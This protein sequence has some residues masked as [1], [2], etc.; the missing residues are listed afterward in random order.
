LPNGFQA[1]CVGETTAEYELLPDGQI[2][3]VNTCRKADGSLMRAEGRARLAER[4]GPAS[5]LKFRFAPS[6][7]SFLP[8]VWGDY[9]VLD[10][11]EDYHAA[12]VGEPGRQYLWILSRSPRLDDP[13]LRRMLATASAQG[14]DVDRLVF[15]PAQTT[16]AGA[17]SSP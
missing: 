17:N 8:M 6:F 7:L 1:R 5:R 14:F 4:D 10:L 2:R 16:E 15:A 9:W 13:T 11:T 3:V 12:L